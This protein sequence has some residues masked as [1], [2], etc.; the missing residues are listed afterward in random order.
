MHNNSGVG[1]GICSLFHAIYAKIRGDGLIVDAANLKLRSYRC[2]VSK[3]YLNMR[4]SRSRDLDAEYC[5]KIRLLDDSELSCDFKVKLAYQTV[6][7]S[8][9][10]QSQVQNHIDL[11]STIIFEILISMNE[12]A[13]FTAS[14]ESL[15]FNVER[16]MVAGLS[17]CHRHSEGIIEL[18][19]DVVNL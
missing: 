14:K 19:T 10:Q 11:A 18:T 3:I 16:M 4:G 17:N 8:L 1:R 15:L 12:E 2:R 13:G 9:L 6:I 7:I 5:C